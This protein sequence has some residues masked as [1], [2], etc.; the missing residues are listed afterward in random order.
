MHNVFQIGIT[1]ATADGSVNHT[2]YGLSSI[3][4]PEI[5][6][7]ISHESKNYRVKSISKSAIIK[8]AFE[9]P[10]APNN[11]MIFAQD[12]TIVIEPV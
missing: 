4:M 2:F 8:R 5:G 11:T 3:P 12:F 1:I 9:R 7:I 6:D 10:P